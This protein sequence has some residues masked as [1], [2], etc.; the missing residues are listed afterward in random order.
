MSTGNRITIGRA[1]LALPPP[2]GKHPR[3]PGFAWGWPRAGW[4][5][6]IPSPVA[7]EPLGPVRADLR[8]R[9]ARGVRGEPRGWRVNLVGLLRRSGEREAAAGAIAGALLGLLL[10]VFR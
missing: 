5:E 9:R 7:G 4:G 6:A 3:S 8:H 10:L 2:A 1:G